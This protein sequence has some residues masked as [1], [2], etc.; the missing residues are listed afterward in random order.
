[1]SQEEYD[2]QFTEEETNEEDQESVGISF[3][4]EETPPLEITPTQR[5]V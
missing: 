3:Q 5:D 4:I 1:M 2:N